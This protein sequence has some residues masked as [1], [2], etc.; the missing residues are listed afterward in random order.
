MPEHELR[1]IDIPTGLRPVL[2]AREKRDLEKAERKIATGLKSFLE[3]GLALK[4]IRDN[5]LYRQDYR[6]FEEYVVARWDF[7]RPR[8]Y[9]LCAAS[10]VM[11]DLSGTPDIRSLSEN[12]AQA[13]PLTRLKTATHRKRAWRMALRSALKKGRPVTARDAE[14]AV[15]LL[16]ETIDVSVS[17]SRC[18]QEP[19]AG[20]R[21]QDDLSKARGNDS[22]RALI[23]E[24][25]VVLSAKRR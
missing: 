14:E 16:S 3:V 22:I 7:S 12:E 18:R 19:G 23:Y 1:V 20:A 4:E 17:R 2:T 9:E 25:A 6:T 10:E 15:N 13:N 21:R 8:A 5:R 11:A 24:P